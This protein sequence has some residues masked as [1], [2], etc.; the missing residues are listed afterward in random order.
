M[1][2]NKTPVGLEYLNDNNLYKFDSDS[3][4][5]SIN[6]TKLDGL[7][8]VIL[9]PKSGP[10]DVRGKFRWKNYGEDI[11][12][13]PSIILTEHTLSMSGLASTFFN[14]LGTGQNMREEYE[15]TGNLLQSLSEPYAKMYQIEK[16]DGF[17]YKLPW[18]ISNG[19]NIRKISNKWSPV[20]SSG[21]SNSQSN[22]SGFEKIIG[23]V[24]G[25]VAG[26]VTPGVGTENV[27]KFDGTD[28]V[29]LEIKFPLYNTFT[30]EDAQNNFHF[31]NL[32]TYQNLK[33]RTSLVTYIPP[34][35][36]TVQSDA[37]GG[38]Y[39]PLAYI[40]DLKIDSIGT[41]RRTDEI[42]DGTYILMPEAYMIS[43]TIRELIPV[44]SNIFQG[45][46]GAADKIE[47]TSTAG[48]STLG[49]LNLDINTG[50]GSIRLG[51]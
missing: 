44:S 5:F 41:T 7:Q 32:I 13:V 40:S 16:R 38:I 26:A 35:V 30:V 42:I 4:S 34:S 9:I 8:R 29:G 27:Q 6:D 25:T 47:V 51:S 1:S 28:P 2:S 36:Y 48:E 12:E 24:I 31:T 15:K 21:S 45:A 18:F 23:T 22:A 17:V 49:R 50:V 39:M 14:I 37:L 3:T 33:N 46:M 43:I 11:E 19:S 20:G 10:I